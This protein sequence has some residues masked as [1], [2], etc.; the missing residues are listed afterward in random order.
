ML[1]LFLERSRFNEPLRDFPDRKL[2]HA[3]SFPW[4]I[5]VTFRV[6]R[7]QTGSWPKSIP[8]IK[9]VHHKIINVCSE[10]HQWINKHKRYHELLSVKLRDCDQSVH[11]VPP[12]FIFFS[13]WLSTLRCWVGSS[14][15]SCSQMHTWCHLSRSVIAPTNPALSCH[16]SGPLLDHEIGYKSR[17]RI[18]IQLVLRSHSSEI[19]THRI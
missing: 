13:V 2:T 9:S 19:I 18:C 6:G 1:K 12:L 10:S 14:D 17:D 8:C 11:V 7:S 4:V 3:D 15:H 16:R 5:H